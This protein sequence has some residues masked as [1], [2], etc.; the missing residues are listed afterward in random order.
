MK[1]T[2]ILEEILGSEYKI[3]IVRFL[4]K[5]RLSLSGRQLA[6]AINIHQKTCHNSLKTLIDFGVVLV[7]IA[8]RASLYRMNE[9]NF[10]VKQILRPIFNIEA[11]ILKSVVV[12]LIKKTSIP[13]VSAIVFGSVANA[14]ERPVSDV[15]VLIIV[16]NKRRADILTKL[17]EN[18]S[19]DFILEYGNMFSP[20]VLSLSE[21]SKRM[22]KKDTFIQEILYHGHSVYGK[23]IQ[24]VI[25]HVRKR[26]TS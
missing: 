23:T 14:K 22:K 18:M 11:N 12:S 25:S 26:N 9:N 2:N 17:L 19:Y 4:L 24:E 20:L 1:Y 8:G 6:R 16:A 21:L 15:D 5:S 3:K 7:D 13:L 10:L